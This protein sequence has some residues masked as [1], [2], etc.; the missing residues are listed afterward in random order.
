MKIAFKNSFLK[1]VKKLKDESLKEDIFEIINTAEQSNNF[2]N[3]PNLKKL[4]GYT[5]Y[6]RIRTGNYRIGLK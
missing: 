1:A 4:K 6:Y 5:N 3:L 2:D